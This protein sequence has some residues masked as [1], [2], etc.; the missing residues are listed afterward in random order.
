[1]N[2]GIKDFFKKNTKDLIVPFAMILFG[3]IFTIVPGTSMATMVRFFG[4]FLLIAAAIVGA[5]S[6]YNR[7][8]IFMGIAIAGGIVGLICALTPGFVASFTISLV[9]FIILFNAVFRLYTTMQVRKGEKNILPF[10]INDI[11]T[12]VIGVIM[13][14]NPFSA[15]KSV[16]RVLGIV[17]LI[18]GITNLI[19]VI[20]VYRN[21]RFVDDGT[22]VV[23]EE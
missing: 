21:G 4:I 7:T 23:W 2:K 6:Y 14:I 3:L 18:F 11:I 8:Y 10:L 12:A 22:D 15:A 17:I 9:G 13:V 5:V 16:I 20:N 1:M 19:E